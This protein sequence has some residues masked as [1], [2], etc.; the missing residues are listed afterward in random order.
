MHSIRLSFAS[1]LGVTVGAVGSLPAQESGAILVLEV[2]VELRTLSPEVAHVFVECSL[3]S[4]A[5]SGVGGLVGPGGRA[6]TNPTNPSLGSTRTEANLEAG[7]FGSHVSDVVQVVFTP[8]VMQGD[9]VAPGSYSCGIVLLGCDGSEWR[10]VSEVE[11]GGPGPVVTPDTPEWIIMLG[12]AFNVGRNL[13][14]LRA[15]VILEAWKRSAEGVK[16]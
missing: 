6:D 2:P 15:T 8:D 12:G 1:I 3:D 16:R 5:V 7:P 13:D 14:S 10:P 9:P 11:H 4:L